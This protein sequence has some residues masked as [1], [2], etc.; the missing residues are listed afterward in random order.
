[1]LITISSLTVM[2]IGLGSIL[3]AA[4]HFLAVKEDPLEAEL[5][6][7]LPGSQCGQ[8]G[9]VGC[10]QAAAALAR[11]EAQVTL[12]T[13]GGKAVAE[14][15]A[16]RLGV[17]VDLSGQVEKGPEY[18]FIIEDLCIGCTRCIKECSVDAIFGATKQ[19]HTVIAEACHACGSCVDVCPTDA[20]VMLPVPTTIRTWHW[21]K[22]ELRP[23]TAYQ[24]A[25]E[26]GGL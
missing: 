25:A 9:Y 13:P 7:L 10:G 3:G 22:P 17:S 16:R 20:V 26:A 11:G 2:G 15:L 5:Q 8:C 23:L 24:A 19:M 21:P 4:A 12:C 1:M 18:A 14:A 6:A